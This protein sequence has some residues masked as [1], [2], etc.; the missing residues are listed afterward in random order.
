[1]LDLVNTYVNSFGIGFFCIGLIINSI[2]IEQYSFYINDILFKSFSYGSLALQF[3][4]EKY[5]LEKEYV[6]Q[7]LITGIE[8]IIGIF[9]TFIISFF[10]NSDTTACPKYSVIFNIRTIYDLF[11]F[12][13]SD[14][15]YGSLFTCRLL[16]CCLLNS[17]RIFV[18]YHYYPVYHII[19]VTFRSIF[20]WVMEMILPLSLTKV[21]F[22]VVDL[23][24]YI[25]EMFG[26]LMLLE[27]IVIS[28]CGIDNDV[29][30]KITQ[31]QLEEF[32]SKCDG[33]LPT[34]EKIDNN[35]LL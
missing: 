35:E 20:S 32:E 31:R 4:I 23:C 30:N 22:K 16:F 10:I 12:T 27:I 25:I 18:I 28:L 1:M 9:F 3:V 17:S 26:M 21:Q 13:F 29:E 11:I 8:G 14:L 24:V 19:P 5:L 7:F 2:N 15:R 33:L 34:D 6:N